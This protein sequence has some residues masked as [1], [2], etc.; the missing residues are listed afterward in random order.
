MMREWN[1]Q[2]PNARRGAAMVEF[3]IAM[4]FLMLIL[5]GCLEFG[6]LSKDISLVQQACFNGARAV[7]LG[8]SV[9]EVKK[10]VVD[11]S[12]KGV[13][14]QNVHVS[15]RLPVL[16]SNGKQVGGWKVDATG[17]PEWIELQDDAQNDVPSGSMVRVR[18]DRF[19]HILVTGRFFQWLPKYD[20]SW[21]VDT[22]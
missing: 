15:Y 13:L 11:G 22:G 12:P 1:R 14:V 3:A 9:A 4:P 5:M 19:P 21:R 10:A 18:V 6:L 8:A 17:R 20:A 2:W 16:D 7:S